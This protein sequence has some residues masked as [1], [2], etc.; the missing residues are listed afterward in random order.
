MLRAHVAGLTLA[1]ASFVSLDLL[2][3]P[4]NNVGVSKDDPAITHWATSVVDY[5]PAPGVAASFADPAK[6]LGPAN[7]SVVSLGDLNAQQI[8]GNI[9]PGAITLALATPIMNGPG[10]DLL[11]F[12]NAG[13]LFPPPFVF[14]ELAYVEVSS[15]GV[16]FVRFPSDSLNVEP[17]QGIPDDT[18]INTTFGRAFAGINATN[19][20]NLAGIHPSNFGTPFNLDDLAT[21]PL[22]QNGI[23]DLSDIRFARLVDIPGNGAYF[24][25]HGRPVLDAWP[26]SGSG[27]L[28]LDA[29]GARHAVP[30]PSGAALVGTLVAILALAMRVRRISGTKP[31]RKPG[32]TNFSFVSSL[33]YSLRSLS[34]SRSSL[35]SRRSKPISFCIP[36]ITRS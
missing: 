15:S 29:V 13:T 8:S 27:G 14:A 22:V 7:G 30:E 1:F 2:A 28:D 23:V 5:R 4:Y 31:I 18:E 3:G 19:V 33:S 21:S 10:W 25:S 16:D 36:S 20:N 34:R 12:E 17:G 24:D 35:V 26:T 9:L 11:I 6:A 32:S